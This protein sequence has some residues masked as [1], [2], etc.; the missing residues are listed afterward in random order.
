MSSGLISGC[1]SVLSQLV[2]V[3]PP[4][5]GRIAPASGHSCIMHCIHG[6]LT[7]LADSALLILTCYIQLPSDLEA[8]CLQSHADLLHFQDITAFAANAAQMGHINA[9][10]SILNVICYARNAKVHGSQLRHAASIKTISKC[11]CIS[12]SCYCHVLHSSRS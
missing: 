9:K 2:S 5:T 8:C 1:T 10:C 11:M 6:I 12:A 4:S 3:M 7:C